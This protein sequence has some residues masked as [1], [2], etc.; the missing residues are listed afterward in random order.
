MKFKIDFE[1]NEGGCYILRVETD[2]EFGLLCEKA[3]GY[4]QPLPEVM[5]KVAKN[6][7]E[8][9]DKEIK[10]RQPITKEEIIDAIKTEDDGA[11]FGEIVKKT[12]FKDDQLKEMKLFLFLLKRL[13][14]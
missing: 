5:G 1:K 6:I 13:V 14:L 3:V 11:E 8:I 12:I 9:K 4:A 10:E 2:K 7:M